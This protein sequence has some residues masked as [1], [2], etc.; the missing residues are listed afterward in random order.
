MARP[1]FPYRKTRLPSCVYALWQH[2]SIFHEV[3]FV[4][5]LYRP[6]VKAAADFMVGFREPHTKL[7]A[8]SWDLWEER[9][10][11]HAYTV[12]AVYAGLT[13]A[14]R[15]AT[16][17]GE[18]ELAATYAQAAQEIQDAALQHLWSE[19]SGR[20]LRMINIL[21]DGTIQPDMT[22]D[23]S[24]TGLYQF[25]MFDPRGEH[26]TR[27]MEAIQTRLT[28]KSNVGGAARYENDYYH[29]VSQDTANVPGNP[30]FICACWLAEYHIA[31][32]ETLEELHEAVPW[33][34]WVRA[35]ALPSGIL[36]EQ[37]DPYTDAPL[38]V[39]PLTW[40]HAEYVSAVRWY[41]GKFRHLTGQAGTV[42]HE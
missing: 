13:S 37:V 6:L 16:E 35:H 34:D 4:R 15:F 41:A 18:T 2:Y 39:S 31:R 19:E 28:I 12:A 27:T 23:S 11:I 33:L 40:S 9:H 1:S 36:A 14:A 32:A 29:Q 24:I 30:W 22:I 38:S 5:P 42:P 21:P 17:F 10:G 3:E 26:I 7:P 25:G 8:P 20:F